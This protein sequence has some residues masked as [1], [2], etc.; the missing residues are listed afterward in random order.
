MNHCWTMTSYHINVAMHIKNDLYSN[1]YIMNIWSRCLVYTW[2]IWVTCSVFQLIYHEHLIQMFGL[3]MIYMGYM[4]CI[5]V[6]ISWTFDPDVWFT[7]DIYGLHVL[8]SSW[9]IMNIWSRR[10]VYTWYLWVTKFVTLYKVFFHIRCR[11]ILI[12][13][14]I[15]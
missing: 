4:F 6:D 7:H 14:Q 3:H 10:L 1:W 11:I 2:Y 5:P 9:Y 12:F 13:K 15:I 8:Y